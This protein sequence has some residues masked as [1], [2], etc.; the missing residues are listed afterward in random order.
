MLFKWI[1][2]WKCSDVIP[3]GGQRPVSWICLLQSISVSA[4]TSQVLNNYLYLYWNTLRNANVLGILSI[5]ISGWENTWDHPW[6]F[7][8]LGA[9]WTAQS[10]HPQALEATWE[11]GM[12]GW[13]CILCA[14]LRQVVGMGV[15]T[16]SELTQV[17]AN[18]GKGMKASVVNDLCV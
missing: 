5:D 7:T 15:K 17:D 12:F 3:L 10:V 4:K 13:G 16:G 2:D 18:T 14:C 9:G 11:T 6:C 8:W 1:K